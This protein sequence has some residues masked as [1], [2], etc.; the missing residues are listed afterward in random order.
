MTGMVAFWRT[1]LMRLLLPRGIS[2]STYPRA[3]SNSAVASR[4]AG[5]NSTMCGLML[6]CSS[7][8]CITLI[9]AR[10]EES[11]SLPPF[12]MQAF[13]LFRQRENTSKLTLGRA[14]YIMPMTPNGTLTF[15]SLIPWRCVC[16]FSVRPTG[17]GRVAT[18]RVS[19]AM[20]CRRS[21]V[22]FSRSYFGSFGSILSRSFLFSARMKSDFAKAA[23]ATAN[24]IWLIS[25][26]LSDNNSRLASCT[27]AN[28]LFKSIFLYF[29]YRLPCK[30]SNYI[31]N[32][33]FIPLKKNDNRRKSRVPLW[34]WYK[35]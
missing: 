14:S 29:F 30:C 32:A 9:M 35:A 17:E 8:S 6:K 16:S 31:G 10:L 15:L 3:F 11:A 33:C 25:L 20:P 23:S 22:S 34:L 21:T 4:S 13:P 12:S 19:A 27:V 18:L 26:S 7:T 2:K 5:S 1:K 24:S 28:T